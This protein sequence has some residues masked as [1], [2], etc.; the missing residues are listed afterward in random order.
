ME[1]IEG[2]AHIS[3]GFDVVPECI[4]LPAVV[5]VDVGSIRKKLHWDVA[6]EIRDAT[7][8]NRHRQGLLWRIL[9]LGLGPVLVGDRS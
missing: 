7:I 2:E 4:A 5:R 3:G 1:H 8:D 6:L 9:A